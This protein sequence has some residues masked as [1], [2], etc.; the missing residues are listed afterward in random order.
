MWY[1]TTC[2]ACMEECPVYVNGIDIIRGIR[3]GVIEEG[4]QVP[5]GVIRALEAIYKYGN[6][7][8]RA[9]AKRGEWTEGLRVKDLSQGEEA[10]LLLY[11]GCTA[12]YDARLQEVARS[13]CMLL[14]EAGV[15]FGILGAEEPCCGEPARRL[16]EDGLFE[17]VV[18]QN[19]ELF[20]GLKIEGVVTLSPHAFHSFKNEYPPLG[21]RLNLPLEGWRIR[22]FSQLLVELIREGR[23]PLK[24]GV[25]RVV[26]YHDPCYLGRH[27]GVYEEP[28]DILRAIPGIELRE[29]PRSKSRSLCCGGGGGRMWFEAEEEGKIAE[30]R[31]KE[32]AETGAEVI[33]TAC[34]FCLAMLTDAVKTAGLEDKLQVKD[35]SE[36]VIEATGTY[37]MKKGGDEG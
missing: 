12:S 1:C 27:N 6:P 14:Q 9:P 7:W 18:T 23:I 17:E 25:R 29:M 37:P 10:P 32:A 15:D 20:S 8:E 21:R 26:T 11:V 28:R 33:A 34:P 5:P 35:I 36:L 24:R 13:L 16:G 4:T 3:T 22:H 31:V 2:R 19:V 30:L